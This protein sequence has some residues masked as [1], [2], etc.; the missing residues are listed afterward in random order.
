MAAQAAAQA[1]PEY[2]S[3]ATPVPAARGRRSAPGAHAHALSALLGAAP[4]SPAP[5]QRASALADKGQD[6]LPVHVRTWRR[7]RRRCR[8]AALYAAALALYAALFAVI[9]VLPLELQPLAP[10][11]LG[12]LL[13]L[14]AALVVLV[15]FALQRREQHPQREAQQPNQLLVHVAACELGLALVALAHVALWCDARGGGCR[16]MALEACAAAVALEMFLLLASV[17][18]FGAAILH[19][20]VSVS[21]PFASY[22]RQLRAYHFAVWGGSALLAVL[23]PAALYSERSQQRYDMTRAEL[24]RAAA[25]A[26]PLLPASAN[27]HERRQRVAQWQA[28]NMAYWGALLL[29]VVLLVVAAQA[30]LVVGWWRSNAGTVIA[31]RARR[32]LMKRMTVYVHALNGAWLAI[33]VSFFAYRSNRAALAELP[34]EH[35]QLHGVHVV[36]A[37]FHYVLAAKGFFTC[38]V[39]VAVNKQDQCGHSED[40]MEDS[41]TSGPSRSVSIVEQG[42]QAPVSALSASSEAAQGVAA[43]SPTWAAQNDQTLQRE[44]IY[45]TVSG[46]TKAILRAARTDDECAQEPSAA[47]HLLVGAARDAAFNSALLT[48]VQALEALASPREFCRAALPMSLPPSSRPMWSD[49]PSPSPSPLSSSRQRATSCEPWPPARRAAERGRGSL[50]PVSHVPFELFEQEIELQSNCSSSLGLSPMFSGLRRTAT[51]ALFPTG[52]GSNGAGS[53]AQGEL[54]DPKP[55]LFMDYAPLEFRAVRAAFGLSDENYLASFRTTAKERVS[56]GASGAFLFFTGDDA[57][58]VKSMRERECRK[59]VK[60]APQYA[61]YV[62]K[63]PASRLIRVLGCHRL[64]LYGRNF[65]FCVM[66]NVLHSASHAA[67]TSEKYDIKGSWINRRAHRPQRG[68]AAAC[69]ECGAGFT[70]GREREATD[71]TD[72][73]ASPHVHRADVILKDLDF[74]RRLDLSEAARRELHAQLVADSEFLRSMGIMDYSLLVGVHKCRLAE[75]NAA[76]TVSVVPEAEES[77]HL[78]PLAA[79]SGGEVYFVGVI[80]ILQEW[81]WEKQLEK[82]GKMLLGKS[83]RGISAVEPG[84]Y[85]RRFQA[86]VTQLLLGGPPPHALDEAAGEGTEQESVSGQGEDTAT[87]IV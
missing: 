83:A 52:S 62:A 73:A 78:A 80:D 63:H 53:G 60:M 1:A 75:P 9:L 11:V 58:I 44:I 6:D 21:N 39:W 74:V 7:R 56:A 36:D 32:R 18:W 13:S 26:L 69:A 10:V 37:L 54:E 38:V 66:A 70:V 8:R 87:G 4:G 16:P 22:K 29:L 20:F 28:L 49:S 82:A 34:A 46:I 24:C 45:Y 65:Y 84:W 72:W 42:V 85:C 25:L 30:I 59:L 76:S 14:A 71:P 50:F 23:V 81:D 33:L 31:L 68:E 61:A 40:N 57:L 17:G 55:K 15:T 3:V 43:P 64:R 27:A 19:L 41:E 2:Q 67:T 48:H 51:S 47:Q 12:A 5:A 35:S 86:R 79:Q 77:W